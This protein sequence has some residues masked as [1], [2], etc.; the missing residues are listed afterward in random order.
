MVKDILE[1]EIAG[2]FGGEALG[3]FTVEASSPSEKRGDFATNIA[4]ARAKE[5]GK[6]PREVAGEIKEKLEKSGS[7]EFK[8][9]IEKIE[10]ARPGFVNF[11]LKPEVFVS[12]VSEILEQEE[13]G[14]KYGKN[15]NLLGRKAIV[16]YANT[17]PFKEFHIGHLVPNIIGESL[18]G[19]MEFS[20]AEVK[21]ASYQGDVGRHIA[22][23]LWGIQKLGIDP[24]NTKDLGS[25]YSV[26]AKAYEENEDAKKEI[27]NINK[28]IYDRSDGE[29][30]KLYDWGR[31]VSLEYFEEIYKKLGTKFDYYFFESEAG[32]VGKKIVE[33]NTGEK[34][35]KV[36]KR[37]ENDAVIYPGEKIG[38]HTRVFLNAEGLPT[39]E[40]KELGV[41]KMKYEKFPYDI[42]L[43]V[44]ASEITE[45]F[46]VLLAA[47]HEIFP[48]LAKKTRHIANGIL[49]LPTG[50]MSSRTGDVIT[51]E[52]LVDEIEKRVMEKLKER[53]L[54]TGQAELGEEEKKEIAEKV[55]IG[56]IKFTI[57][58]GGTG[59]DIIFDFDKSISFEG[60]SG[61]YLQYTL[62]RALSVLRKEGNEEAGLPSEALA[63]GGRGPAPSQFENSDL[64]KFLFERFPEVL[65]RA[66]REYEP[67]YICTYLLELASAFNS[68]YAQNQIVGVPESPHRLALTRALAVVLTNG[69]TVL[70]IPTLEK[71]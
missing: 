33:E 9:I 34:E 26:G 30:N 44:A 71:M 20:G 25:A 70:G 62:A 18:A 32:P 54:P 16:E 1:K 65:A 35:E 10:V 45:Y 15:E 67:H 68:Y 49:K 13:R 27:L 5:S 4:F 28:K 48:D 23:T 14:E 47:M 42:S 61:P 43:V 56:A 63:K 2:I 38:L 46:K 64:E 31:K 24:K 66:A 57:L 59:K 39:Y 22:S 50:K 17:N 3:K 51:A 53:D 41:A 52:W 7:E 8:K 69:L 19:I 58:R 40:A 55:A 6:S 36:F 37:G 60:D 12:H 21:R 29:I 11:Y